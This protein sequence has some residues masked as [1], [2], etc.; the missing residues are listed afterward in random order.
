MFESVPP[1]DAYL[2]KA[3]LH[4][5]SDD[6]CVRILSN[7]HDAAPEDGRLLARERLADDK[8]PDPTTVDMD[9]WMMLETGG[10]ERTRAEFEALFDRAG[11]VLDDVLA[12]EDDLSIMECRQK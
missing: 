10:Q 9:M 3:I 5:W 11:W 12:V 6:D 7:V 8:D 4:D 1:A 2:L